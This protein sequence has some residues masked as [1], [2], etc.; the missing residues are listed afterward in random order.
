MVDSLP[1]VT[2]QPN[3]TILCLNETA[4]F[5]VAAE[6]S[7]PLSYQWF[8]IDNA[9]VS[10]ELIGETS[11]L[12]R[13]LNVQVT[14]TAF[15]Y[16]CVVSNSCSDSNSDTASVAMYPPVMAMDSLVSDT[17]NLCI[18][19][20]TDIIL[21]VIGGSGDS[22]KWYENQ[23]NGDL[24]ATTKET[25]FSI[26]VP[27]LTTTFY[28]KWITPCG[29]SN[30]DSII[31]T[32]KEDPVKPDT[33]YASSDTICFDYN[34]ELYLYAEGGSGDSLVWYQGDVCNDPTNAI[35]LVS[36]DTLDLF[37]LGII[38]TA[39]TVYSVRWEQYCGSDEAY[40][41]CLTY[42]INVDG[43]VSIIGPSVVNGIC[44]GQ[45]T[46][47]YYIEVDE[48]QSI[49]ESTY[50]WYF[51]GVLMSGFE[52]DTLTLL[53][54]T[55]ADT[56][57]YYCE[58]NH[59][60][61]IVNSDSVKLSMT[62]YPEITIQP[63]LLDT[64]CEGDS[65]NLNFQ[66][67]GS[68]EL[69][70][71]WYFN[72][73]AL[74]NVDTSLNIASVD[75]SH[76][77]TYFATVTNFCGMVSTDTVSFEVDTIPYVLQQPEDQ[78][79]CLNGTATFEA[80]ADGSTPLF[81]QWYKMNA[82]DELFVLPGE[83]GN[84]LTIAPV[85]FEDTSYRYLCVFNNECSELN[86]DT[87]SLFMYPQV[88]AMD[89][90]IS[91][92]N[93]LCTNYPTDIL[94]SVYGGVG[95]SIR[96]Y[97]GACEGDLLSISTDT[98]LAISVPDVTTTYYARWETPC[99]V[100]ACDSVTIFIKDEPIMPDSVFSNS[101][102][103]CFNY[104]DELYLVA[105]GGSGDSLVWYQGDI[106]SNPLSAIYLG[107][108][109]TLDLFAMGIIPNIQTT[110]SVRWE[111][112]C[113]PEQSFSE[114]L[115]HEIY[116][117][118]SI[119][120]TGPYSL[121][122]GICEGQDTVQYYVE[123]DDSQ[124]IS[125]VNYQWL[126]NGVVI[127]DAI[128][129]TL[130]LLDVVAADTGSYRCV[131]STACETITTD[132]VVLEMTLLP[133]ILIN[134]I[135]EPLICEG[136][137]VLLTM[138]ANGSSTLYHQ[139]FFNGEEMAYTDT[140]VLIYPVSFVNRGDYYC[141]VTNYCGM[142]STDTVSV[143]V[144]TIP[145][146]IEQP[147]DI[148]SCV[149]GDADFSIQANGSIPIAYQW[150]NINN[151]GVTNEMLGEISN[152]LNFA[153]VLADDS[154]FRYFCI[155][156]NQC[157]DGISSDTVR[158]NILG[159]IV[160][161]VNVTASDTNI[162]ETHPNLIDLVVI[163]GYGDSISWYTGS[164]GGVLDTVLV[165]TVYTI[166]PPEV[167]TTYFAR[168]QNE[169]GISA[170]DSVTIIVS[171][172]PVA[173]DS[174]SFDFNGIC[175]DAYDSIL[176]TAHGGSG[177]SI[178]WIEGLDC[179]AE[180]KWITA[181]TF[182]YI[183][184]IP[185]S[186]MVYS[187]KWVNECGGSDC[188]RK[189]LEINIPATINSIPEFIEV[190]E[191]ERAEIWIEAF[192]EYPLDYQWFDSNGPLSD[193]NDSILIIDPVGLADV[194]GYYCSVTNECDSDTSAIIPLIMLE[195]PYFGES[196]S[197]SDS[198]MCKGGNLTLMVNPLG[199]EPITTRWYK[200]GFPLSSNFLPNNN[201]LIIDGLAANANYYVAIRNYCESA[202]Y[203]DTI[204]ITVLDTVII[205]VQPSPVDVCL[206]ETATFEVDAIT[207][208]FV[209]YTWYKTNPV[210]VVGTGSV[211]EIPNVGYADEG[212]YYCEITDYCGNET[213]ETVKLDVIT[214]PSYVPPLTSLAFCE[215]DYT[216]YDLS[217]S[218]GEKLEFRWW[219]KEKNGLVY[220]IIPGEINSVLEFDPIT[221][222]HE[223]NYYAEVYNNC[224]TEYSDTVYLTVKHLP[225]PLTSVSALP[226]S[227]CTADTTMINLVG[228]GG[229][230]G[231]GEPYIAWYMNE[232]S[233]EVSDQIGVGDNIFVEKQ[234]ET[235]IYYAQ[236]VNSCVLDLNITNCISDTVFFI[237]DPQPS[238]NIVASPDTVICYD[239]GS[240]ITLTA[241]D[242]GV[243]D[244]ISWYIV[245]SEQ[246]ISLDLNGL[247]VEV[248]QPLDTTIYAAIWS[249]Q[250]GESEMTTI[251][252]DVTPLPVV[253][254]IGHDSICTSP[255]ND[256]MYEV[257]SLMMSASYY[258]SIKWTSSSASG[259]FSNDTILSPIYY[260]SNIDPY[261][262]VVVHLIIDIEGYLPCGSAQDTIKL[263]YMPLS[264]PS[265]LPEL[266]AICR[267]SIITLEASGANS[268]TWV[269]KDDTTNI[270]HGDTVF[271]SPIETSDYWL[272]GESEFG[273]L[274]STE[275]T[276]DVYP[277]PLV[278]LGDSL[279]MYSCEPVKLDAGGGDGSEYYIWNNGFRTRVITAYETGT[280]SVIVG[281]PGCEVSDTGYISLCNGRIFM[282]TA[283]TPNADGLN[284]TFKPITSDP[285][286][287]FH[288]MI[289]DRFGKMLFETYDI[290]EGW[291]GDVDGEA[292][293]AGNYV[294]RI[295]YQGQGTSAPGKKGSEVGTV[296]L[297]R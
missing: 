78:I 115:T 59:N 138:E 153:P 125:E 96:W 284:E 149:N 271:F 34:N 294:W 30:C 171:G 41:D 23:C 1:V 70:Y 104:S 204:T 102:T 68:S 174:L 144:D 262:T 56:G 63:V 140:S 196:D 190:C 278:D 286:V 108:G 61:G 292:C 112:Y 16:Y 95:D 182:V 237:P 82:A 64:I 194:G 245:D 178:Y 79:A 28:A 159:D 29:E 114:C 11:S 269:S 280:Y 209:E 264:K 170:C 124:S 13:I 91:D 288:M 265:V 54:V 201:T 105:E 57:Y 75:F 118:G 8:K 93:N 293:P 277:T 84:T 73:V 150:Y 6:G 219:F 142:V 5:L 290:H 191:G 141:T 232:C 205:N 52:S 285:S 145:Y 213:T 48:S 103:I 155:V 207:T 240:N 55:A 279:F 226:E 37:D 261:D 163:G 66:A 249:N 296:M 253:S 181:D 222:D 186:N 117:D 26:P 31:I 130:T 158:V 49:S 216:A 128:Y 21:S 185:Q 80:I 119:S 266:L 109:D 256:N 69:Q 192:G 259:Y 123:V 40:S 203:S 160:A 224:G 27:L 120:V 223:G 154:T 247:E 175:S 172:P 210:T 208:E 214:A 32:I 74:P 122:N 235:T 297:V 127:S 62:L 236:W 53:D 157:S 267:D 234:N 65:I 270:V 164:C 161:P 51:D 151:S 85:L 274:D 107:T 233:S 98:V 257:D 246:L 183:S 254:T 168:W 15:D 38:P 101:D 2:N 225:S 227:V 3:D 177:D 251:Q 43:T 295:D 152:S 200:N 44:E 255:K 248:S 250:C 273:C 176:L 289:F 72:N 25:T 143:N 106:C 132:S 46:V 39:K 217:E 258:S 47:Q 100:S 283:F 282:P 126:F 169:C 179:N 230:G 263:V 22:I 241:S 19:Y 268:Y 184:P 218:V 189:Q 162:C 71:Q 221:I 243:G 165:D 7:V 14:D 206:Q 110:Y 50:Q 113:G 86:S 228:Q 131:I 24:L 291:D 275:F 137:S 188:S 197:F 76:S 81:Y 146:I 139:W 156:S 129:D 244:T 180:P 83:I 45:D 260:D 135:V 136:D 94:L 220:T 166:T 17:N 231:F 276:I 212:D 20:P 60:C 12:Y 97:T 229:G 35:Y 92:T 148:L 90:I 67:I 199:L 272:I 99:A 9:H 167:T 238:S 202:I 111:K 121:N 133:Q 89:S 198:T 239:F 58:V 252:I 215:G 134:P 242:D 87:V 287:E 4:E 193:E 147:I 33:I 42:T 211:L 116:V 77:G 10:T 281:N 18:N 187:A 88:V 195:D 36:G 173:M